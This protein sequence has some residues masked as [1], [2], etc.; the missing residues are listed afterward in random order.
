MKNDHHLRLGYWFRLKKNAT[1]ANLFSV[2]PADI[3]TR[4]SVKR[5]KNS[6]HLPLSNYSNRNVNILA[7]APPSTLYKQETAIKY[8]SR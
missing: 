4:R 3:L 7:V 6:K 8:L 5:L 2:V 1:A